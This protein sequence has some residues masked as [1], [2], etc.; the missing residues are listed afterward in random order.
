MKTYIGVKLIEAEPEERDGQRGYRVRYRDGYESWCPEHAFPY[1][2]LAECE[3]KMVEEA[4]HMAS[5]HMIRLQASVALQALDV[6]DDEMILLPMDNLQNIALPYGELCDFHWRPA[7]EN[8]LEMVMRLPAPG[9][10]S[11]DNDDSESH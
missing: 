4:C 11:D 8:E 7:T 5:G 3:R 6:A 10:E 1:R 9:T 2:Q